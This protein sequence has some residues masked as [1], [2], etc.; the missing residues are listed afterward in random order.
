MIAF[1]I[2]VYVLLLLGCGCFA[3]GCGWVID[4]ESNMRDGVELVIIGLFFVALAAVISNV[5]ITGG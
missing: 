5:I 3:V 4:K 1:Y 2:F